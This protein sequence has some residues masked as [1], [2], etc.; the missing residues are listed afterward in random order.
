[1]QQ[2]TSEIFPIF[3]LIFCRIPLTRED[4]QKNTLQDIQSICITNIAQG[5]RL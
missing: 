1:M 4:G 3:T 2:K 5:E